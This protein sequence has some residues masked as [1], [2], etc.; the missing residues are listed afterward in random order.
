MSKCRDQ[1]L[2]KL[3][4]A[5]ELNA[6]GEEEVER[7]EIHLLECEHC[8]EELKAFEQ[9]AALLVSD[10]DIRRVV[11][12]LGGRETIPA[13]SL[14][15]RVWRYLWPDAP[16]LFRPALAWLI[17]LLL[18]VPAYL[19]LRDSPEMKIGRPQVVNLTPGRSTTEDSFQTHL[20]RDG[21]LQFV[22]YGAAGGKSY[23]V[24]IQSEEGNVIYRNHHFDGFDQY[25]RAQL[26]FPSA[27]MKPGVYRLIITDPLAEPP[28]NT[29]EYSFRID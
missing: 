26:V 13:Q 19:G 9:Q 25:G 10:H 15:R 16:V 1:N 4:P 7:F 23:R 12:G 6:L 17:I 2:G 8:F 14:L 24:L 28:L 11:Q 3:L 22:F 21:L 27:K 18:I 5:Y 29:R 20:Q